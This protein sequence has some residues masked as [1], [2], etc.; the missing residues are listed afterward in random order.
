MERATNKSQHTKLTLENKI[1]PP[2]LPGFGLA[3]FRSRVRR[4]NQQAIQ[5]PLLS[6]LSLFPCLSRTVDT[7]EQLEASHPLPMLMSRG[8]V[9]QLEANHPL[10][11]FSVTRIHIRIATHSLFRYHTVGQPTAVYS[12]ANYAPLLVSG[13]VFAC[14]LLSRL[15]L[16]DLLHQFS[17]RQIWSTLTLPPPFPHSIYSPIPAYPLVCL[18]R[19]FQDQ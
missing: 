5:A 19:W 2:L 8:Y 11:V 4:S 7:I 14:L 18:C 13:S 16:H 1:L 15:R 12:K 3:T 9:K 6:L 10:H 17:L